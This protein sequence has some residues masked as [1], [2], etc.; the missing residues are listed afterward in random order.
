MTEPV[1]PSGPI[2][3]FCYPARN[4]VPDYLRAG[5]GFGLTMLPTPAALDGPW[6]VKIIVVGLAVLFGSF[7]VTTFF[8]QKST[9]LADEHGLRL[10][11]PRSAEIPWGEVEQVD[12]RYFSTRKEKD[13]GW[14]Q[15]KVNG[16]NGKIKADSNL[17]DM[18][19]L[20]GHVAAAIIRHGLVVT[21]IGRENF[22]AKGHALPANPNDPFQVPPEE[23]KSP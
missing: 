20:L 4:L 23:S 16:C 17:D 19:G 8:R 13:S 15:L 2:A 5:A 10:C 21:P 18:D 6:I 1:A 3:T 11:G 14:L 22:T 7:A 9:I 12:L